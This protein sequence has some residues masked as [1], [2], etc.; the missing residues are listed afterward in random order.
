MLIKTQT[1]I[2]FLS[3][4][5]FLFEQT[6]IPFTQE[7]FKLCQVWL[8]LAWRRQFSNFVNVFL[9]FPYQTLEKGMALPLNKFESLLPKDALCQVWLKLALW[10]WRRLIDWIVFYVV[11]AI[12]QPY[13]SEK[14]MKMWKVYEN[15]QRQQTNFDQ[16]SSLEPSAQVS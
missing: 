8:K 16:K 2:S 10:F 11:L 13:N 9:P 6:W 1:I 3:I 14:K 12:L 4:E 5:C 7:C 15:I